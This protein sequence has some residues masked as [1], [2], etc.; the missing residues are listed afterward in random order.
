MLLSLLSRRLT[1]VSI[2]LFIGSFCLFTRA[3][4][5]DVDLSLKDYEHFLET[6]PES[7]YCEQV[8]IDADV[9]SDC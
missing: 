7:F 2:L 1:S 8:N 9:N 3:Q 6:I 4:V 5:I